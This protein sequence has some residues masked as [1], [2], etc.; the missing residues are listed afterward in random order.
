MEISNLVAKLETPVAERVMF[1]AAVS[2]SLI[3]TEIVFLVIVKEF[4]FFPPKKGYFCDD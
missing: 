2:G 3:V 4:L 1:G